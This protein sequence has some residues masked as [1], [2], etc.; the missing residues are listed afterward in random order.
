MR[1]TI[2]TALLS[3]FL[4]L[5]A[6]QSNNTARPE[7]NTNATPAATK[8]VGSETKGE[9]KMS[10]KLTSTAFD[11]GGMIP[12][13]YTCDGQNIS[14]PLAWSGV[15][16]GAKT[17]ALIADDPDAP[18]GTWVHWVV[19]QIPATEKGLPE[20]VPPRETLDN[21]ARA[22]TNDFKKLGYGGP[23]PPSGTHRYF[24]KLYALDATLDLSSG[25]TKDQLL[26]ATEGHVVAEG[27]LMGRYQRR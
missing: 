18:R 23:C 7:G 26:K 19:Y 25:A 12:A 8:E 14:P 1:R 21:G 27:Q 16:E 4:L 17:L 22:G 13:E 6:C 15:P 9:V 10:I 5:T 20:N 3:C 24:F 11:E 2:S